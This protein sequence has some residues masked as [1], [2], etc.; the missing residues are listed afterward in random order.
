MN[1]SYVRE[2]MRE[3]E[4]S[5]TLRD[6][7]SLVKKEAWLE[8]GKEGRDEGLS[9]LVA[10]LRHV[11]SLG[12]VA[13]GLRIVRL[14]H[15]RFPHRE[16]WAAELAF[17]VSDEKE[18]FRLLDSALPAGEV[19]MRAT[20]LATSP[21][22]PRENLW[23]VERRNGTALR[24]ARWEKSRRPSGDR[25]W[26]REAIPMLVDFSPGHEAWEMLFDGAGSAE[27]AF[28]RMLEQGGRENLTE[29]ELLGIARRVLLSGAYAVDE[30]PWMDRERYF[31]KQVL[32]RP[33]SRRGTAKAL[34]ELVL[35]SERLGIPAVFP[36]TFLAELAKV[37]PVTADWLERIL[38]G[39][40]PAPR[41]ATEAEWFGRGQGSDR[42]KLSSETMFPTPE[43]S[44]LKFAI[45]WHERAR[46]EAGSL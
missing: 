15:E 16:A 14:L 42:R 5:E 30:S 18:A 45:P 27:G 24:I 20:L 4:I 9:D 37:D 46:F 13:E 36:G 11:D 32:P 33:H 34:P 2:E 38:A 17:R 29:E 39:D 22:R 25:R 10:Q 3:R 43:R 41:F 1:A 26:L 44:V 28:D 6:W 40:T 8:R 31:G 23:N 21:L 12:D 19:W 35:A 7:L